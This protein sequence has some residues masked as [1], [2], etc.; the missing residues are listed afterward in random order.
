VQNEGLQQGMTG[1]EERFLR[2]ITTR[3]PVSSI[4]E[5]QIFAPLRQGGVESGVAVVAATP[6]ES[7]SEAARAD[8]PASER[9]QSRLAVHT[10]RYRH[11]QK[12]VD[13]GKWEFEMEIEADAPLLAIDRVVSG[14]VQRS[15]EQNEPVRMSGADI[16]ASIGDSDCTATT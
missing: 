7:D 2:E 13:R 8:S 3:L 14:V 6:V 11:T 15:G 4:V 1:N 10:A 9:L 12:G 16:R 5:V